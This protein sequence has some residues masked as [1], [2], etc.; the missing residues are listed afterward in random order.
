MFTSDKC[1]GCG[2]CVE[3]CPEGAITI[4][5]GKSHIDKDKCKI[6]HKCSD[7]CPHNAIEYV[8]EEVTSNEIFKRVLKDQ[9]FYDES[10]GGVTFSGGEPMIHVDCVKEVAQSCH[11]RGIHTAMETSGFAQWSDFEKIVDLIDLFLFD[12]KLIDNELHRQ[13]VGA[14]NDLIL[15]N[16]KK[17]SDLNKRIGIR[18]PITTGI[19]DGEE[20]LQK[21]MDFLKTIQFEHINLLPYHSIGKGKYTKLG[22]EYSLDYIEQPSDER[23]QELAQKFKNNE[24]KVKIG[25]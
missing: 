3:R 21:T 18:M 8:G 6:C 10:G 25:G 16:I 15:K 7:C 9:I 2:K 4:I 17:L 14:D 11:D 12:I 19:N 24:F 20:N 22:R 13:Y 1:V 23:M 5:D